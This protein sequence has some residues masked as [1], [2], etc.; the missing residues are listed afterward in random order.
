MKY[1][2]SKKTIP[3][4]FNHKLILPVIVFFMAHQLL[5]AQTVS[6]VTDR[7]KIL[8]GEQVVLQLKAEDINTTKTLLDSWFTV[9]DSSNH[10]QIIKREPV[11]TVNINGQT[12]YLQKITLTSFDSGRWKLAPLKIT[13]TD[14]VTGKQSSLQ[15]DSVALEV[16]PVNVSVLKNYH[17]VKDILDVPVQTNYM[18]Y[19][20]I[21]AVVIILAIIS[22]LIIKR[23]KNK[24]P[25]AAKP[26]YKGTALEHAIQQIKE[27]QQQNLSGKV[28]IKL[29]YTKLTTICRDYFEDQLQVRSSQATSDE[30]MILLGVYLQDEKMRTAFYQLLRLSDAVKFAKYLPG[31][32]QNKQAIDTAIASLTHVDGLVKQIKQHA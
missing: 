16:I 21:T 5:N 26:V 30:L 13:F 29:F 32:E 18:L 22:W 8:I 28:N 19:A 12:T 23:F 2:Q 14:R 11:D 20:I 9:F 10:I 24:K 27:L 15:T 17:D 4:A 6:A 25:A 7:N 31:E 1:K 3:G